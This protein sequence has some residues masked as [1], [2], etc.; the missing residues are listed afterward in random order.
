MTFVDFIE[1]SESWLNENWQTRPYQMYYPNVL[2]SDSRDILAIVT[3]NV[4]P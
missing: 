2:P 1:F 4:F 3:E